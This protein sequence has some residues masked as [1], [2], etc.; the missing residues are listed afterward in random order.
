MYVKYEMELLRNLKDV[1]TDHIK[2][3]TNRL[4]KEAFFKIRKNTISE[5]N[6]GLNY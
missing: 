1:A 4:M 2:P 3:V 6:W 5:Q